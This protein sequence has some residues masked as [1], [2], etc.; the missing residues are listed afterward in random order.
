LRSNTVNQMQQFLSDLFNLTSEPTDDVSK[1][2]MLEETKGAINAILNGERW[3][4][5]PPADAY[6][7]R[8][9]HEMARRYHLTSHSYGKEPHRRVR[10]YRE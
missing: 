7:R 5:L 10:I 6:I 8:L 2:R 1:E 4:E 3:I 9:Q